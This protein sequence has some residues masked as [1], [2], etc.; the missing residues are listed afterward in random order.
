[1]S[2]T[3]YYMVSIFIEI[4]DPFYGRM[5]FRK[6]K[7]HY[8]DFVDDVEEFVMYGSQV[9]SAMA[10]FICALGTTLPI[11]SQFTLLG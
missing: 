7:N 6:H 11:F 3:F 4:P 8:G 1:M 2:F 9:S 10:S 5:G